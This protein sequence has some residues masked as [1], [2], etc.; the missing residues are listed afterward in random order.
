[1]CVCLCVFAC[2]CAHSAAA[3]HVACERLFFCETTTLNRQKAASVYC[4]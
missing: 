1:V 4:D 2:A 3:P